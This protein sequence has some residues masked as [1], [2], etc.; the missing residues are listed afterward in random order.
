[1]IYCFDLDNTLCKTVGENYLDAVPYEDRID[2]VN[3][4]G[5]K[6][7][8]IIDTARGTQTGTDWQYKTEAQLKRW[9]L[10]YDSLRTGK[11]VYADYYIDDK[12]FNSEEFFK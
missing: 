1:M 2:K 9:G 7:Y 11:K 3:K 4:L 5:E 6:N 8:I 12:G 10:N